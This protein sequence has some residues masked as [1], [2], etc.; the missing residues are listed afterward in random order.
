[1]DSAMLFDHLARAERQ[2]AEG[3]R[4][5]A[6]QRELVAK[7]GRDGHDTEQARLLLKQF[8]DLLALHVADRDRLLRE[9]H[10]QRKTL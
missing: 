8:E 3:E 2:V 9:V 1:M 5:V 6:T 7:L 10:D 4:H